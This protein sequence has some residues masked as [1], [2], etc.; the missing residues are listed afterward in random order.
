[1]STPK[2]L[3][4]RVAAALRSARRAKKL[5]QED[6]AAQAGCSVETISNA[7]RG[8]TLPGIE[9]FL[10][11]AVVL[12]MNLSALTEGPRSSRSKARLVMEADAHH[13]ARTLDDERLRLW[14]ETGKVFTR[15]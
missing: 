13:L 4:D 14:L 3:R 8:V 2:N 5:T 9:L 12:D 10:E 15:D 6:L 7:E 1:M 11:L